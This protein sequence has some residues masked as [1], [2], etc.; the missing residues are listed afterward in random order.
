MVLSLSVLVSLFKVL[1][2]SSAKAAKT[3]PKP[4]T[5]PTTNSTATY[6]PTPKNGALLFCLVG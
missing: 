2:T 6:N 4:R 1:L 5:K 3:T